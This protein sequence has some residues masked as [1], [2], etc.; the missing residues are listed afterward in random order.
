VTL[1]VDF[2]GS[3]PA[4]YVLSIS[5]D[6]KASYESDGKLTSQS[7]KADSDSPYRED[8][9][10]SQSTVGRVLELAK[11]ANYFQGAIDSNKKGLASTGTK[12]LTYR[13]ATLSTQATYNY[14]PNSAVQD[15]TGLMQGVS[16]T[17][18][19]GRRLD[20][21]F[22]YQKLALDDQL[23]KMEEATKSGTLLE[24]QA[25]APILQQI[26]GDSTIM[27]VSRSRAQRLLAQ[28]KATKP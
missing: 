4:H 17:L 28:S 18:E 21:D 1:T 15:L 14:S 7:E 24:L 8:F 3:D 13:D 16:S 23:S 10:V 20:Y 27:N 9:V 25:V 22:R 2:P 12:T 11:R 26:A 19:A 6:G 5:A